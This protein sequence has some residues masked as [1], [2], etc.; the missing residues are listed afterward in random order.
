M[1]LH[2][3]RETGTRAHQRDLQQQQLLQEELGWSLQLVVAG[4]FT[5]VERVA[6]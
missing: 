5:A 2:S 6:A 1:V 3:T 4:R